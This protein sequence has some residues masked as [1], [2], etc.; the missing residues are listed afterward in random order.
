M[1]NYGFSGQTYP[2]DPISDTKITFLDPI[3]AESHG[4]GLNLDDFPRV[5]PWKNLA[6]KMADF[7]L[8]TGLF[9]SQTRSNDFSIQASVFRTEK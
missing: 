2:S 3:Q 8:F 7:R 6:Q 5:P 4:R 1:K 9:S